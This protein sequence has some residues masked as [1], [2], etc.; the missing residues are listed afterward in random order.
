MGEGL[1]GAVTAYLDTN[2]VVWLCGGELTRIS[3]V[4]LDC[5]NTHELLISP[6]VDLELQYMF[7]LGRIDLA[8]HFLILHLEAELDA[9]VCAL[10][11]PEIVA[12]AKAESWTRD[13]FD[14][15]ITAHARANH[16]SPLITS[17]RTIRKN[18]AKAVW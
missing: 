8:P 7:E 14:R 9:H 1:V 2:V 11:L 6:I 4:A 3:R 15:L 13:P 17:D 16:Y 10:P 18:Y 5:V 12:A